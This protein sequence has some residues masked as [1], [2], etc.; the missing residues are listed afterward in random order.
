[1][2]SLLRGLEYGEGEGQCPKRNHDCVPDKDQEVSLKIPVTKEIF[3][4][5]Y[6][7][8]IKWLF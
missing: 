8:E 3:N 7:E 4:I 6:P 2:I 1:M 5:S